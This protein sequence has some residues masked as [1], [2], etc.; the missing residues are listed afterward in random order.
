MKSE[1]VGGKCKSM[2]Y[3]AYDN[4]LG[5]KAQQLYDEKISKVENSKTK[6]V[7]LRAN[8]VVMRGQRRRDSQNGKTQATPDREMSAKFIVFIHVLTTSR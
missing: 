6:L 8:K 7:D 3:K 2:N 5:L 4:P 1:N